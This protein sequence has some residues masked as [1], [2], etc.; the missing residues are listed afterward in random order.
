MSFLSFFEVVKK[1]QIEDQKWSKGLGGRST[2]D[3]H[4]SVLYIFDQKCIKGL[5][6]LYLGLEE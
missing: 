5:G 4:L 2:S 3:D 6:G 1:H